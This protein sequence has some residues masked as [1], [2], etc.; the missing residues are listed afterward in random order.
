MSLSRP[1]PS[2]LAVLLVSSMDAASAGLYEDCIL[3][4]MKGVQD[5]LAAVEIRRACREKT[6][7]LR[8]RHISFT[9]ADQSFAI[10]TATFN[11]AE[12]RKA[13]YA[14]DEIRSYLREQCVR[15]CSLTSAWERTHGTCKID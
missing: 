10:G 3:A 12:A 4:N 7:P 6:T 9:T 8:C 15:E 13:G 11:L 2:L 1:L 5:R 14:E